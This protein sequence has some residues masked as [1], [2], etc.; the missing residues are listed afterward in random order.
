LHSI[1][2]AAVPCNMFGVLHVYPSPPIRCDTGSEGRWHTILR[3]LLAKSNKRSARRD[4]NAS[5]PPPLT[6]HSSLRLILRFLQSTISMW[7]FVTGSASFPLP[8]F[9]ALYKSA[10]ATHHL[11]TVATM[12]CFFFL[13]GAFC[14]AWWI[15]GNI[16]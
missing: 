12:S 4:G 14:F 13:H 2:R 8:I 6:V 5:S 16:W 1:H 3:R 15:C 9:H 10:A 7:S 11:K